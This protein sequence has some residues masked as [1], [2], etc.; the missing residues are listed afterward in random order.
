MSKKDK[1]EALEAAAGSLKT[2]A[3]KTISTAGTGAAAAG[4][5]GGAQPQEGPEQMEF[6]FPPTENEK[7]QEAIIEA[8][9]FTMGNSVELRRLAVAIGQ[10]QAVAKRAVERL[11]ERYP[12]WP[13]WN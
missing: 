9:L 12:S 10:D 11:M 3:G 8:V 2:R 1:V 7:E 13:Y 6:T 5:D 4:R